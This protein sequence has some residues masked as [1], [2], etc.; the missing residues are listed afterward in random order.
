MELPFSVP[1]HT[2]K[3]C[4]DYLWRVSAIS[5]SQSS[6]SGTGRDAENFLCGAT[7]LAHLEILGQ[8]RL[9][10]VQRINR[11]RIPNALF[12][13]LF[14]SLMSMSTLFDGLGIKLFDGLPNADSGVL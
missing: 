6:A 14:P 4:L 12:Q 5:I 9:A 1:R 8:R 3:Q 10:G 13:A 7:V 11:P 2:G